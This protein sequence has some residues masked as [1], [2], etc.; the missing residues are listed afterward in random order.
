MAWSPFQRANAGIVR[1]RQ[2][3]DYANPIPTTPATG[4]ADMALGVKVKLLGMVNMFEAAVRHRLRRLIFTGSETVFGG[5]QIVYGDR[6]VVEDDYCSPA[7]I[8]SPTES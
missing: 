2:P 5:W 7:T 3:G 6:P 8:S 1:V 4:P